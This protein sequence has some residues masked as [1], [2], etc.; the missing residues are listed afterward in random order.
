MLSQTARLRVNVLVL[1]FVAEWIEQVLHESVHAVAALA[2]G[3][4]LL[5]VNFWAVNHDWAPG[6][7]ASTWAEAVVEGSAALVNIACGLACAMAFRHLQSRPM[8]R[9]FVFYFGAYSLFAGFG[10][11]MVDPLFA[12]ADSAGDWAKIVMLLGGGWGVRALIIAVGAAGTLWGFYWVGGSA[13][14][15]AWGDPSDRRSRLRTGL[16]LCVLPYVFVSAVLSPLVAWHPAGPA[17]VVVTLMKLWFGFIGFFWGFMIVYVFAP[18]RAPPGPLTPLPFDVG[19][20]GLAAL[21]VALLLTPVL[22]RTWELFP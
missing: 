2:V 4:R 13:Q 11:L 20:A 5:G 18:Y 17:G 12:N 10:Y 19:R 3:K 9:L 21:A 22:L 16:T 1:A 15:F 14:Q 8:L 7:S 6:A